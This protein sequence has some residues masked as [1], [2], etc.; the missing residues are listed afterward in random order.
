[1]SN[2]CGTLSGT[3]LRIAIYREGFARGKS[4]ILKAFMPWMLP[5]R[6][7]FIL[8]EHPLEQL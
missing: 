3:V 6:Q 4:L 2:R 5:S 8:E 1:M 7:R